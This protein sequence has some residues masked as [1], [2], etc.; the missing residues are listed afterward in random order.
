ME[1]YKEEFIIFMV[2]SRVLTF[3]DFTTKSGRATPYFINTGN[4]Q[5]GSQ[6]AMLGRF[7][8]QAIRSK[9]GKDFNVLFGPAYKGIPLAVSAAV[10]L[11]SLYR[12]DVLVCFNR[13]E[14]KDHGEGGSII[15]HKLVAGDKIVIVDDVITAGTSVRE[16]VAVMSAVAGIVLRALV[17]SVDRL[18]KG[19]S[20]TSALAEAK[21]AYGMDAAAIVTIED[22]VSFL[23]NQE[24]DGKVVID[25]AMKVKIDE[26]RAK[27]GV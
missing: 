24:I 3:G 7:Y 9:L 22:I 5:T 13:K 8:A 16:S 23:H 12:H 6:I 25:D 10:A 2:Q 14:V 19:P 18:E 11:N 26:Y 1:K 17:V 27:Y 4:Y 21:A 15:G 20:G